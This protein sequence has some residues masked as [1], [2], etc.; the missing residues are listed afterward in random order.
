MIFRRTLQIDEH[1]DEQIQ[2]D[3]PA[4]IHQH[5]DHRQELRGEQHVEGRHG[6]K[7]EHEKQHGVDGVLRAH[8]EERK[9][10]NQRGKDV[11]RYR[12]AH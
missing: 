7:V 5:L 3:D 9:P 2:D 1:H 6:E 12:F 8:D 10:E 4:G 11:K